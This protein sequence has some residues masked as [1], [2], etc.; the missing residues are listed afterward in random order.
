MLS[1]IRDSLDSISGV[2]DVSGSLEKLITEFL[3]VQEP[4]VEE[5]DIGA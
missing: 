5:N 4:F 2:L 1:V 3:F